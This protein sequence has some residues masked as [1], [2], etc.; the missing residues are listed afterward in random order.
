MDEME[1]TMSAACEKINS[2][3]DK[4]DLLGV[5]GAGPAPGVMDRTRRLEELSNTLGKI[6]LEAGDDG[7]KQ[8]MMQRLV[9]DQ[10]K[11]ME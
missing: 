5:D 8:Q 4:L 2:V 10:L 7:Q 11:Q 6:A 1:E 9:D 3:L